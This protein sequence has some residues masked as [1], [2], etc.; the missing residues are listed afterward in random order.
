MLRFSPFV[1]TIKNDSNVVYIAKT[2]EITLFIAYIRAQNQLLYYTLSYFKR[3]T[4]ESRFIFYFNKE[5]LPSLNK[6]RIT[7]TKT[8]YTMKTKILFLSTLLVCLNLI[9]TAN[10][11]NQQQNLPGPGRESGIG[12]GIG[13]KGYMGMGGSDGNFTVT[14]KD[15]WEWDQA[16]NV[17]TQKADFG[18]GPIAAATSFSIGNKGYVGDGYNM[19]STFWEWDQATNVWSAKANYPGSGIGGWDIAFSIGTKGYIGTGGHMGTP[20]FWE[21]NQSAN[22]WTQKANYPGKGQWGDV[23]FSIG[24]KGYI[25]TGADANMIF[26]KDFWAWDQATNTWT[27][28]AD[29]A[30]GE[31]FLAVGFS[32]GN[33]GYLGTGADKTQAATKDF[34]QYDPATDTWKQEADYGGGPTRD[35]CGFAVGQYGYIGTGTPNPNKS[36]PNNV[37]WQ[38]SDSICTL[39]PS[40]HTDNQKTVCAGTP[41]YITAGGGTSYLWNTGATTKSIT[42]SPVTTSTFT[43]KVD[44]A[45]CSASTSIVITVIACQTGM[46]DINAGSHQV[47]ISPN[48]VNESAI[49]NIIG[50]SKEE[51]IEMK[52]F[53]MLGNEVKNIHFVGETASLE[54]GN[55]ADGV[56]FYKMIFKD[57]GV[58]AGKFIVSK[59]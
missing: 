38:W 4:Y 19:K 8:K 13:N 40:V 51:S 20:D 25:G 53:D 29:Y 15:F 11:W 36:N 31:R 41:V 43:V 24:T 28:K 10:I 35:G 18:G 1:G 26:Y 5:N 9:V 52:I 49:I 33:K 6:P 57:K 14:Y 58:A 3:I 30:G 56:Y 47:V 50:V 59:Q 27:Q 23:G 22:A 2:G 54:R 39:T 37:F 34:W 55:L 21:W 17:W 16:T 32:I 44:S 46:A 42:V 45:S 7:N 12:F 48:P